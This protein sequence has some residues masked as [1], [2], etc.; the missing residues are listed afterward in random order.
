MTKTKRISKRISS[1][2]LI[3]NDKKPT[4]EQIEKYKNIFNKAMKKILKEGDKDNV[5]MSGSWA[6]IKIEK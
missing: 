5:A 3:F 6:E 2:V 4:D 1:S